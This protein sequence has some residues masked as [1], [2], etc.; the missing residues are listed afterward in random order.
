MW[1]ENEAISYTANCLV[2]ISQ[3][4]HVVERAIHVT[5]INYTYPLIMQSSTF[6]FCENCAESFAMIFAFDNCLLFLYQNSNWFFGIGR[7]RISN[8]LF[9]YKKLYK[10]S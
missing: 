3:E 4:G 1:W 6:A 7:Q 8:F 5:F 10:L 2:L 9:D